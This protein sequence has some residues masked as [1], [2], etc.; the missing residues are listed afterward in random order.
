MGWKIEDMPNLKEKVI[1][2]TGGNRGLGFKS[3]LEFS[4]K[5]AAVV[6]GS[7]S[8]RRGQEAC[9]RIKSL[10]PDANIKVIRLDLTDFNSIENFSRE[11]QKK[12]DR[13]DVLL[14]N[15]GVISLPER[16]VSKEGF[17]MH[18]AVNHLG[19]FALVGHLFE[20][21]KKTKNSRVVIM[22]SGASNFGE[23]DFS[24]FNWERREY[25]RVKAYGASKI[26]NLLFMKELQKKFEELG[27]DS[28]AVSAQP[29]LT[30]TER[31]QSE[32]MGGWFS[33]FVATSV[34]QGVLPQLRASVDANVKAC[35]YYGPRFLIWG[36]PT[37]HKIKNKSYTDE[38]SKKLWDLSE[39]LTGVSF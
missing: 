5:G 19:H 20:L 30:A 21:I 18:M 36:A 39:K 2:V 10:V 29:G 3:A 9:N 27:V 25:E 24:D 14:N 37:N 12:F 34:N 31:Q 8:L 35:E 26:A 13:L 16:Q 6:I 28:I 23:I 11:F 38:S 7:R 15:A 17:E 4:K 22:S 33:K 32:G 1:I